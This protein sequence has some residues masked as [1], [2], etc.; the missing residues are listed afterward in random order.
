[1]FRGLFALLAMLVAAFAIS[2]CGG[3]DAPDTDG[4]LSAS[5]LAEKLPDGG[6]PQATAVDVSAAKEAAGLDADVEPTS[7]QGTP[8]EFRF[9][10]S[11]FYALRDLSILTDNPLRAALDHSAI[12]AYAAHPYVSDDA[13]ALVSTSQDFD[14]VASS[15]EA[16]GWER[17][18]DVLSTDGD[19]AELGYTAAAAGDGF[20]VLGTSPE[21]VEAAASGDAE[22]SEAGELEALAEL[23]APVVFAM[24]P[25]SKNVECVSLITFEDFVDGTMDVHVT[26]DGEADDKRVADKLSRDIDTIGFLTESIEAS[27]DTVTL[28]LTGRDEEGLANSPALMVYSA[29]DETGPLLYDCG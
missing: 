26:V 12:T 23:D 1:M 24:I 8:T 16:D 22:P 27:G 29:L 15:L 14:D 20:I 5:E 4:G 11:T 9:G 18:G 21:G 25:E 2:A 6:M 10:Q 13:V 19:P 3:D 17:D 7:L 28:H